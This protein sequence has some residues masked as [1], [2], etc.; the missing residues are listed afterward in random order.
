MSCRFL[1]R[2]REDLVFNSIT[3]DGGGTFDAMRMNT[4]FKE[5]QQLLQ[6]PKNSFPLA[7]ARGS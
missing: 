1:V 6:E 5:Q 7:S 2:E 4:L 3:I